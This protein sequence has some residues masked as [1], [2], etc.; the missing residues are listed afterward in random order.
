MKTTKI[1]SLSAVIALILLLSLN[2]VTPIA[3]KALSQEK[4]PSSKQDTIKDALP[5]GQDNMTFTSGK[6]INLTTGIQFSFSSGFNIFFTTGI[7]I[8][9][10][11]PIGVYY[12]EP[13]M[14]FTLVAGKQPLPCEWWEILDPLGH[15]TG[16][17]FHVDWSNPTNFHVDQV[18]PDPF[19]VQPGSTVKAEKKIDSIEWCDNFVVYDPPE[20]GPPECSWWEITR[21]QE[22]AGV[23][24]HVD[25]SNESCEFHV[26]EVIG[27]TMPLWPWPY[28]VEAELKIAS[29]E[30]CDYF[31]TSPETVP[32]VCSWWEI[33]YPK[34]LRGYEFHIDWSDQTGQFHIDE[35]TPGN[36]SLPIPEPYIWAERK[37]TS[38]EPCVQLRYISPS[39]YVPVQCD[40]WEIVYPPQLRGIEFHIDWASDPYLHIDEVYPHSITDIAVYEIV[41][42]KKIPTIVSCDNFK[43][44]D[45][46][47][48]HPDPATYW[49][50]I[51]P[52]NWFGVIFH[53]DTWSSPDGYYTF[54]VDSIDPLPPA[55]WPHPFEVVAEPYTPAGPYFKPAYP[56]Y[57]P[58]GMPDFDQKQD[59]WWHPMIGWSWCGP[60]S[61][62]NSLWWLDSEY[63]SIYF[64]TPVPPPTISDHFGLVTSYNPGIWDDHDP[65]N[66]QP[67]VSNLAWLMDTDGH[68]TGLAH[69][70]TWTVDVE[71]G[72]SQYLQQQGVNPYGDC[73]GDGDV[74][75][76]D[77]NIIMAAWMSFPGDGNWDMRADLNQDNVVDPTD[78]AIA[79]A[80]FGEVGMFYEHTVDFPMFPWIEE[81]IKRCE[82]V[83]LNLEFWNEVAPGVW[84]KWEYDPTGQGGHYVTCAGV[85]SEEFKLSISDPY[86]DAAEAGFPGRVLPPVHPPTHPQLHNDALYVSQD[87]YG[88]AQLNNPMPP[89]GYP[90]FVWEL[91]GYLQQQGF[92]PTWHAFI[93]AAVVTSPIRD[94]A[95]TD[96]TTSKTGCLPVPTVGE[97]MPVTINVVVENQGGFPEIFTVRIYANLLQIASQIVSLMPKTLTTVTYV[98]TPTGI[99]HI[100]YTITG[101]ADSV[102][103]ETDLGDNSFV[104]GTLQVVV[105][106]NINGDGAVDSTDLGQMGGAWGAFIGDPNWNPNCDLNNDGVIDST[107]LG[108]MGG[109]WGEFEP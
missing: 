13:C 108:I 105:P 89:P 50:I 49:K 26:D 94:V 65:Q 31:V 79:G 71:T 32:E 92:D 104:G 83:V 2:F 20:W 48:W 52:Q 7:Y 10:F 24:F 69:T 22:W 29:I 21:P 34:Y 82:D 64:P 103:G 37:I 84:E 15:P 28:Y 81:E 19:P 12:I 47:G 43:I 70:G 18:Y 44:V 57:A 75:N 78:L 60:V 88:V 91:V 68:R 23:E 97:G 51:S 86:W 93:R 59:A 41:V 109:H 63:E 9:F 55:P 102:P 39:G 87:E 107:D 77:L 53:I 67:L 85:N 16:F 76:D 36:I 56:D 72:I 42:E 45:P 98:W 14:N 46:T 62:A 100:T 101:S 6:T 38:I 66:L 27:H 4:Q 40:W 54:H 11:V 99:A 106:G 3:P 96:V 73:D 8:Q 80:H 1:L 90:P 95:V 74:D 25:W 30:P 35:V 33:I 61:V 58:S 5:P 17:E